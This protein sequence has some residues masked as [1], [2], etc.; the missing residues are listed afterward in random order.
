V[1]KNTLVVNRAD[2]IATKYGARRHRN[3]GH[4]EARVPT[5]QSTTAMAARSPGPGMVRG[6]L[7][8]NGLVPA[9]NPCWELRVFWNW[10]P[11]KPVD[12]H[13]AA[14]FDRHSCRR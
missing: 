8:S 4:F 12:R 10:E 14:Q 2:V 9:L 3:L 5:N 7:S 1:A 13:W 11:P 6:A